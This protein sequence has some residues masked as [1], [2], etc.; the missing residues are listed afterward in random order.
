MFGFAS[1]EKSF[2]SILI[3]ALVGANGLTFSRYLPGALSIF[4]FCEQIPE[5]NVVAE[6][7]STMFEFKNRTKP[8]TLAHLIVNA[9]SHKKF[10]DS[11]RSAIS[12]GL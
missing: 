7:D 12:D 2:L 3:F 9:F 11:E 6:K 8:K 1:S 4:L 10:L 5:T